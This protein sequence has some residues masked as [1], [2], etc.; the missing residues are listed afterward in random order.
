MKESELSEHDPHRDM[1]PD[2]SEFFAAP[3]VFWKHPSVANDN[4]F[5]GAAFVRLKKICQQRYPTVGCGYGFAFALL[6]ALRSLG[7]PSLLPQ[8]AQHLALP[9]AEAAD[10]MDAG[11]RTC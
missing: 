5:K 8:T 6:N 7:A 11:F 1:S 2:S 10:M 4:V 9:L 3:E